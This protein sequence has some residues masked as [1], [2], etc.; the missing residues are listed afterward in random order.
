MYCTQIELYPNIFLDV[1][2]EGTFRIRK[3]SIEN[4]SDY[5]IPFVI[6]HIENWDSVRC[7]LKR[8]TDCVEVQTAELKVKIYRDGNFSVESGGRFLF[9]SEKTNY[10]LLKN[11]CMIFDSAAGIYEEN[12]N[13]RYSHWFYNRESHRYDIY[14]KD[15]LIFDTYFIY[16]KDYATLFRRFNTLT[17]PVPMPPKKM[18]GFMQ[19]QHLMDE[20]T[21][22]KL[23][24]MAT[25]MREKEIPCDVIL[26]DLEWGDAFDENDELVEWGSRMSWAGKYCRPLSPAELIKK[27]NN[28]NYDI[29][30]NFHSVPDFDGRSPN[31]TSLPKVL[32]GFPWDEQ[33]WTKNLYELLDLGI[34][35]CWQDQ[36]QQDITISIIWNILKVYKPNERIWLMQAYEMFKTQSW[37]KHNKLQP[38]TKLIGWHRYPCSWTGDCDST[39]NELQYQIK[40]ITNINGPLRGV[41]YVSADAFSK[42]EVIQAR[43]HQFLCFTP[44]IKN[45]TQK[46]WEPVR[47]MSKKHFVYLQSEDDDS[48]EKVILNNKKS[49]EKIIKKYVELRYSLMP[50]LYTLAYEYT[51]T[52]MPII[53]PMM[54]EFPEDKA[55]NKNQWDMQYM[56]GNSLLVCPVYYN[57]KTIEIYLPQNELWIDFFTG[58]L[59]EGGKCIDYDV[60]DL[61]VMPVFIRNG[62]IIVT[63]DKCQYLSAER[64]EKLYIDIYPDKRGSYVLYEDDGVTDNYLHGNYCKTTISYNE[65]ESD[66]EVVI[67]EENKLNDN[68][69]R[70][71][72]VVIHNCQKTLTTNVISKKQV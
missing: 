45:H 41:S 39:W 35:G 21:Q 23:L 38:S 3:I 12:I 30:L 31:N 20:G 5:D 65:S 26:V 64:S 71:Y 68:I 42:D 44:I 33:E 56:L 7:T 72:E 49:S 13:S 40:A 25:T 16:G 10:G 67:S 11:G 62:S 36:R 50:Y 69:S 24:E 2:D 19:T 1:F 9:P 47:Y 15:D 8:T 6:G 29:M 28:M 52:G 14:I 54:I 32:M 70:T 55:C 46:P 43:W 58:E 22:E 34:K 27:L 63:T 4:S 51:N 60:S 48:Y 61:S 37:D 18:F 53:R 66:I 17:G 57:A 59:Y